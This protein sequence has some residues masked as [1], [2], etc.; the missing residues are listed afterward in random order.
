MIEPR[1]RLTGATPILRETEHYFFKLPEFPAD[2]LREWLESKTTWRRH[3]KNWALGMIDEGM[4][5]RAMTVG[6]RLGS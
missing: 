3:V 5:E 4:P 2:P 6:Y 1:S